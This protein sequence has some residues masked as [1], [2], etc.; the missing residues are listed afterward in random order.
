[1]KRWLYLTHRWF[2]VLGCLLMVLWFASGMVMMYV[3]YPS[4]SDAERLQALPVLS[5]PTLAPAAALRQLQTTAPNERVLQLRLVQPDRGPVYAARLEKAGWVG[6]D[7]VSG[8]PWQVDAAMARQAAERFAGVEALQVELIERD[9][10]SVASSMD[11]HRPLFAVHVAGGGLHYVSSR[12]GEVVRDTQRAERGWNWVGAVVHWVYPTVLRSQ[13]KLWHWT[14][15]GLS[16][17]A[18]LTALLGTVIG[19]MRW[20]RYANGKRS[21]YAGWTRWHHLLGLG[22][23]VF[24]LAWL[25]SGLLSMNPL[26]VFSPRRPTTPQLQ[27]WGSGAWA[28]TLP[29]LTAGVKE[30]EWLPDRTGTLGWMRRSD[31]ESILLKGNLPV[32]VDEIFVPQRAASMGL[33]E[34]ASVERL[35]ALDM[36]YHA[37]NAPRPL[38]VWRIRFNDERQTWLHVDGQTGQPFGRMDASNRTARWLYHGLH[39]WDFQAL[40]QRRPLWDIGMLLASALGFL[41]SATSVVIAWR[42]LQRVRRK[43]APARA[44]SNPPSLSFNL[45]K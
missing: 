30:I 33:G 1:M 24:V 5:A 12:T 25:L 21:P 17:Y 11:S 34:A 45:T 23:A 10:W 26:D 35:D 13:P 16:G 3:P 20:R 38:P 27:A 7:A 18:L 40:L 44:M 2:G 28:P 32:A 29:V 14:V 19:V 43:Q 39:S 8:L 31:T 41:F 15:V 22:S 6:I 36:Y 37:R 9:Q 4:L 42:R